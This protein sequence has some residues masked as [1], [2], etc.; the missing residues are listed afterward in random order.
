VPLAHRGASSTSPS[1]LTLRLQAAYTSSYFKNHTALEFSQRGQARK[2]EELLAD[3]ETLSTGGTLGAASVAGTGGKLGASGTLL[4]SATP[5]TVGAL[6]DIH[7]LLL[8]FCSTYVSMDA[9]LGGRRPALGSVSP[10]PS[11]GPLTLAEFASASSRESLAALESVFP[12]SSIPAFSSL[13]AQARAAQAVELARLATGVRLFNREVGKGGLGLESTPSRG[14]EEALALEKELLHA[15]RSAMAACDAYADVWACGAGRG[16]GRDERLLGA[17]SAAG[18]A[19]SEDRWPEELVNRRQVAL[20]AVSLAGEVEPH[21]RV[22]EA[23]A[24]A[25]A[26]AVGE[27]RGALKAGSHSARKEVVYPLFDALAGAWVA[28]ADARA[29]VACARAVWDDIAPFAPAGDVV[30][31]PD[32]VRQQAQASL[33][34]AGR[35]QSSASLP[36]A[37]PP[38][39]V[40]GGGG[41]GGGGEGGGGEV[42]LTPLASVD[43]ATAVVELGG[44]CPVS[45]VSPPPRLLPSGEDA[46]AGGAQARFRGTMVHGDPSLGYLAWRGR[47]FAC[48]SPAAQEAFCAAPE[49]Y[50]A[51]VGALALAH[52][53]LVFPLQLYIPGKQG[54]FPEL[55]LPLLARFDGDLGAVA[56]AV[57]AEG[58][59]TAAAAPPP[60]LQR[61][62]KA[63]VTVADVGVDTPVHFVERHIDPSYS[64]SEWALRRS[65]LQ[66]ARLRQCATV[67]V[68]SEGSNFRRDNDTQVYLPKA[69]GMQTLTSVAVETDRVRAQ[70]VQVRGARDPVVEA[71]MERKLNGLPAMPIP[72]G[73]GKR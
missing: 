72:E 26:Q 7:R 6:S 27:L 50:A 16:G 68:Q 5:S 22:L 9:A 67:G 59:V 54:H 40:G 18:E 43:P 11:G 28:S 2:L 64:F 39:G 4:G 32:A 23:A 52:P 35:Q 73:E 47:L 29:A 69:A 38:E 57:E 14:L 20:L 36:V 3:M 17:L 63:G 53:A 21:T 45:L 44:F 13:D 25:A 66:M 65:A 58:A 70:V 41:G 37:G 51:A 34:L 24:G 30:S 62:N 15:M 60:S 10:S 42:T 71:A 8:D 55:N 12:R 33:G 56:R 48:A 61:V 19:C 1:D 49:H 46:S 31:L